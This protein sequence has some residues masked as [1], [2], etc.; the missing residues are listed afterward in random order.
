MAENQRTKA[1]IEAE[2]SAA[3]D[4]L[5]DKLASL[6][7]QVHPRAVVHEAVSDARALA[8]EQVRTVKAEFVRS[9]GS[10]RT[11]RIGLVVAAV[12]GAIGFIAVLRSIVRR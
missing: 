10:L 3:V 4:G 1:E 7:M 8:G 5:S 6:I 2:V 12:A 11:D 9:D